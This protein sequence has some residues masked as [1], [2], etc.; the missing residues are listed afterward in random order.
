[1]LK[2]IKRWYRNLCARRII[3]DAAILIATGKEQHNCLALSEAYMQRPWWI[4][5]VVGYHLIPGVVDYHKFADETGQPEWWNM[6]VTYYAK[7]KG[8][9]ELAARCAKIGHLYDF[10]DWYEKQAW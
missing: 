9:S 1:M 4:H 6:S 3:V 10:K 2:A 8:F 5:P 7:V